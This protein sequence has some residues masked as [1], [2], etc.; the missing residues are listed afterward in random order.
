MC[1]L[2]GVISNMPVDIRLSLMEFRHR[3][4]KNPHGWGF[5]FP[6]NGE[7]NI[8]KQPAP[9]NE[10]DTGDRRF[11]FKSRI[12]I[13]HVRLASCGKHTRPN[14]HPFSLNKW[15]FVHNGTVTGIMHNPDFSLNHYHPHG[16]TD[17]EYALYRLVEAIEEEPGNEEKVIARESE[18]IR[19]HGRFNFILSDG[20]KLYAH[21]DDS[22][23]YVERKAPFQT[24][25]LRDD[26]YSV[27]LNEI[28]LSSERAVIVATEPLTKEENWQKFEGLM[29]FKPGD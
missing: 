12:T 5:A 4:E 17:S 18:K 11:S 1:Q 24:V 9:L 20:E 3:G 22:L 16:E 14:T 8:I 21:G 23:Y 27:H 29:V 13:G 15:A 19:K 10:E 7:W 25:T 6:E 28:K 26:G 2:L